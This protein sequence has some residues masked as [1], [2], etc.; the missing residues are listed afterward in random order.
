MLASS[1]EIDGLPRFEAAIPP[2]HRRVGR[3][4][5]LS[6]AILAVEIMASW[7]KSET[8]PFIGRLLV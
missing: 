4:R 7:N 5:W 6:N 2:M 3:E 1:D 8:G